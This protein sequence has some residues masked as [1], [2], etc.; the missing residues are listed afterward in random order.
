MERKDSDV[1][2]KL[3]SAPEEEYADDEED[4][5][6]NKQKKNVLSK[7]FKMPE[8][9]PY[10]WLAVGCLVLII[11]FI[12]IFPKNQGEVDEKQFLAMEARL[13]RLEDRI[14][15]IED[16]DEKITRIWEQAKDFEQFKMR[17]DRQEA[18][19]SLRLDDLTKDVNRLQQ[20]KSEAKPAPAETGK[21][22]PAADATSKQ[23]FH[24]VRSGETLYS[25]SR[26]Y[27]LT[28]AKLRQLN[29]LAEGAAIHPDQ[30]LLV[31][32]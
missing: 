30:K 6:W 2:F 10:S 32:P 14:A 8:D 23:K 25:I 5:L 1:Q 12:L 19:L 17:F 26:Q 21:P 15:K 20:R 22:K 27:G 9:I 4:L 11:L 31:K 29:Q 3:N 7:W 13:K 24:T 16:V 28:V 18:S